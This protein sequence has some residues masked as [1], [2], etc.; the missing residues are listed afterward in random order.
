M[1]DLVPEPIKIFTRPVWYVFDTDTWL[2]LENL[3]NK[4]FYWLTN[5]KNIVHNSSVSLINNI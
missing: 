5:E 4:W 2:N 1:F 3:C